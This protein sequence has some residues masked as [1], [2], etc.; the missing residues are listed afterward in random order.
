[1]SDA[2]DR[3]A[4][5]LAYVSLSEYLRQRA[6]NTAK[7][8]FADF[9]AHELLTDQQGSA[10]D[11]VDLLVA[12]LEIDIRSAANQAND[13]AV[14]NGLTGLSA[15]DLDAIVNETIADI[16]GDSEA[17]ILALIAAAD[18][19]VARM[20]DAGVDES[21][22]EAN[23][24]SEAGKAALFVGLLAALQATAAGLSSE[25][26]RSVAEATANAATSGTPGQMVRWRTTGDGRECHDV[27][28]NSC[29][30]RDGQEKTLDDWRK[31]GLPGAPNLLCSV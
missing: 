20:L 23:L 5:V 4:R 10:N 22:V 17:K 13:Y 12:S 26:E 3:K 1:M 9:S 15:D 21:V 6:R 27:L 24:N 14:A 28:E 30:A 8:I 7:R 16:H 11:L 2:S 18:D 19:K 25:V 29:D 31:L